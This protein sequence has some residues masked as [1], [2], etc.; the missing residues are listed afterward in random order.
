[1]CACT[2][3]LFLPVY[4]PRDLH[5]CAP[6]PGRVKGNERVSISRRKPSNPRGPSSFLFSFSALRE[7]VQKHGSLPPARGRR[8]TLPAYRSA[9]RFKGLGGNERG[10]L[11]GGQIFRKEPVSISISSRFPRLVRGQTFPPHSRKRAVEN[12]DGA[13]HWVSGSPPG[14]FGLRHEGTTCRG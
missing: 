6:R 4:L 14:C 8:T 7:K 10:G 12:K 3:V 9:G 2:A 1:M 13:K 5:P 11:L